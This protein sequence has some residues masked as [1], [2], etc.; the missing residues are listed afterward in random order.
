MREIV[1]YG[2]VAISSLTM[3]AYTVRMF[4]GGLVSKQTEYTVMA[5]VTIIG[6]TV[7]AFLARDVIKRR[8]AAAE[9]H[10]AEVERRH[11]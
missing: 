8:R 9:A 5:I 6:A 11:D 3:I 2:I 7:L 4:I 10:T 1:I